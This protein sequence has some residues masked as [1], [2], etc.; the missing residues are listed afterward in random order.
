MKTIVSDKTPLAIGPYSQAVLKNGMLFVSGQI[1]LDPETN[2]L[3]SGF[4]KQANRIFTNLA[5]ILEA[6]ELGISSI[7][8][9]TIFIKD[10]NRFNELNSIYESYFD[11]PFPAREVVEISNLPK[12]AELEIS[13]I[14]MR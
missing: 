7:V 11:T 2:E 10:L 8:K 6:A 12:K 9:V 3:E 4:I 1:G 13:V 5:N 14:A